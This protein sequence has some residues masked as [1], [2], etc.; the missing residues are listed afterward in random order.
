MFLFKNTKTQKMFFYNYSCCNRLFTNYYIAVC[1]LW[2]DWHK[3]C[4]DI[5]KDAATPPSDGYP[6]ECLSLSGLYA[7]Q[8]LTPL[9]KFHK[10]SPGDHCCLWSRAIGNAV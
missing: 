9:L 8:T 3:F 5:L 6:V 2:C 4:Y 7:F 10:Y 1:L